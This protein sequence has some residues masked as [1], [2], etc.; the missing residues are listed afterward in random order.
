MCST[1]SQKL[2]EIRNEIISIL[3]QLARDLDATIYLFGSYAR[4]DHTLESDVDIV[5]V[6][7]LFEGIDYATRVALV[8]VK[9]PSHIDFDIIPLTPSEFEKRLNNIFFREISKYWIKIEPSE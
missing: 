6:S 3:R 9:L 8:R 7:R 5:V 4:G 2:S 1:R